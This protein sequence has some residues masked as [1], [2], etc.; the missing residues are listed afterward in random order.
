MNVSEAV[1]TRRSVRAFLDKPVPLDVL[2]RVLDKARLSPSGSNYQPW[3]AVVLTGEHLR[4]LQDAMATSG[5]QSP[6]EYDI[7]PADTPG[8][9]RDRT[10]GTMGE[11]YTAAGVS[12]DDPV[13]RMSFLELNRL[14]FGAPAVLICHFP[15]YMEP[16]QWADVG[17]WLQTVMLLLREEGLDS[18]PQQYLSFYA[19]LIK[20][21]A[22]IDDQAQIMFCALAIGYR[23]PDS[24]LNN[25]SRKRVPLD[26]QV[27]FIGF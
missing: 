14:S 8:H 1:S 4:N 24:P 5:P 15:R 21:H 27:R 20:Q 17:M 7:S 18:C 10:S 19:R 25:C 3:E 22:N 9:L 6:V 26:E 2:R 13:G 23:D 11:V 16:P 12:R